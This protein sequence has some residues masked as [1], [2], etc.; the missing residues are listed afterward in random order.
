MME[1]GSTRSAY[2]TGFLVGFIAGTLFV[3]ILAIY[4]SEGGAQHG[5]LGNAAIHQL[6]R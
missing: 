3:G 2:V 6:G 5:R 4:A 1:F